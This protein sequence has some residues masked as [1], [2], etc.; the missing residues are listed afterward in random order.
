[1]K[2][3]KREKYLLIA[4]LCIS[5][6]TVGVFLN[7]TVVNNNRCRMPVYTE[8]YF[9]NDNKHFTF[10]EKEQVN[11]FFLTDIIHV[12]FVMESYNS[13]GDVLIYSGSVS[14]FFFMM[15]FIFYKEKKKRKK[16]NI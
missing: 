11:Y 9:V 10:T 12:Y 2:L 16:A 3:T 13:I 14:F 15:K 5:L 6:S 7:L 1:M 8:S 4:V